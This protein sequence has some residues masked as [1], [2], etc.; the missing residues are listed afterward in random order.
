MTCLVP[1]ENGM[2]DARDMKNFHLPLPETT[3]SHL[4]AEAARAQ[5]PATILAREAIDEWLR[6]QARRMRHDSIASYALEMAGTKFDLDSDLE[7]AGMEHLVKSGRKR[8]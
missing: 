4:K 7:S 8:K 3:Y 2:L 5:V 6:Q 1:L